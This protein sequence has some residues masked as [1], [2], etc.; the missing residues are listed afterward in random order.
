MDRGA[1]PPAC[2]GG[3]PGS[4]LGVQGTGPTGLPD[5]PFFK[6]YIAQKV[7]ETYLGA[8]QTILWM[9]LVCFCL[10]ALPNVFFRE[11]FSHRA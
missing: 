3:V 4:G 9:A 7:V 6:I 11:D 10:A 8:L 1:Q 2:P 5:Q